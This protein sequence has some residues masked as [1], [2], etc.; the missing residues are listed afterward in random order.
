MA[1]KLRL[2]FMIILVI[3]GVMVLPFQAMAVT[4][5]TV[6]VTRVSLSDDGRQLVIKLACVADEGD[7][8]VPATQITHD[9]V[10]HIGGV[11]YSLAGFYLYEVWTVAGAVTAPDAAD[12]V[13]TDEIPAEIY[14][15]VGI[16]TASGTVEGTI[17]KYRSITSLLTVTVSN[18]ATVD[19][20]WD[21]YLKLVR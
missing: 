6:T 5:G 13:I 3:L 9:D 12:I 7:G 11:R 19:A 21:T 4:P 17:S 16:I 2:Q 18:Q 20:T 15:E 14:S 8:S 1:K 10:G